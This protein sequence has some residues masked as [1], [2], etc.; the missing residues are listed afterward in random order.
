L[1]DFVRVVLELL[2]LFEMGELSR[3][4]H[5]AAP[6][7]AA[8]LDVAHCSC[9]GETMSAADLSGMQR[10]LRLHEAML[11]PAKDAVVCWSLVGRR[12]GIVKDVRVMIS[13]LVFEEPWRW[14]NGDGR[15]APWLPAGILLD[16]KMRS[17]CQAQVEENEAATDNANVSCGSPLRARSVQFNMCLVL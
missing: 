11:R 5:V 14:G 13:K 1:R 8:N 12:C 10:V 9:F 17:P 3:V 6:V 16:Q 4:L 7:V 15:N 2:T